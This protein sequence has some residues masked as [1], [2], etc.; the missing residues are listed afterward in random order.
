MKYL[1]LFIF[2]SLVIS[3]KKETE[4]TI[5]K[6]IEIV[7]REKPYE[8]KII[9]ID[10]TLYVK[11]ENQDLEFF[12][13]SY[14]NE[15]VWQSTELRTFV[16]NEFKNAEN[17]GLFSKDYNYSKLA[18][19]EKKINKL[20]DKELVDYDL[21]LTL[22]FQ[23]YIKH[24][25]QG[26]LNPRDI[27]E[28]WDLKAKSTDV[29]KILIKAFKKQDDF[30]AVIDS[31]KPQ[32]EVYKKLKTALSILN[33][34]PKDTIK[35]ILVNEKIIPKD[36]LKEM[37][38]IKRR[39]IYWKDL[40]ASDS[41]TNVYDSKT[42]EAVKNFQFRHGLA[43]DGVIGKGTL[44]AL[45]FNKTKRKQQIITNMERWKWFPKEFGKEYLMVNIP[46]Y[47]LVAVEEKDTIRTHK[48][49]VGTNKRKTPILSSKLSYAVFNPTWTV[50]PTILKE[51]VIPAMSK[52]KNYLASKNITAY[53][54]QGNIVSADDWKASKAKSYRY[55]QS[56][57]SYNSLGMVKIIF[58]N[59]FS[60]Y[61]H[62]TNHRDYFGKTN[63]SLSSGCVRVE[64]PLE[65]TNYLLKDS[66][67]YPMDSITSILKKLDTKT[68]PIKSRIYLYQWY[69]TAWSENSK[70]IFRDDIYNLDEDLY[71]KL[72]E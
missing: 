70:L 46:D 10:S 72:S 57:G 8:G 11:F 27:Y 47:K 30:I 53:D 54:S 12:Y 39:L 65:L 71:K 20:S 19:L 68:A 23:K 41:L 25:S 40:K 51:D 16:L 45:N 42:V 2:F 59:K 62:D 35:P 43:S 17:E 13:K 24:I 58:P 5:P 34:L 9:K 50:P 69:W 55:V 26:K 61:L 56:P 48:V 7:E 21:L 36:T 67:N 15:T 64:N 38:A 66:I 1:L 31:C 28:D 18:K 52:N 44:Y 63:R 6:K 37:V 32:H 4:K 49:I 60:V 14:N 3:C 29:S 33:S 22:N